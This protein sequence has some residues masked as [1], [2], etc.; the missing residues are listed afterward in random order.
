MTD[1]PYT[2][3]DFLRLTLAVYPELKEEFAEDEGL[4]YMQM[5]RFTQ[6]FNTSRAEGNWDVYS[7]SVQIAHEVWKRPDG[8]LENELAVS[9]LEHLSFD[10]PNGPEGWERLTPELRVAWEEILNAWKTAQPGPT[11]RQ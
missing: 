11:P 4:P 9:C 1:S 2:H 10:G 7:R 5:S 3:S 6:H 8:D